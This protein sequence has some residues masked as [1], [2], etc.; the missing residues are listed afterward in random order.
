MIELTLIQKIC[1]AI[2]PVLFAI[3]V[4]EVAH[5]FVANLLGD[6]T[7]K[8][9]GR[10]SLNPFKHIDPIG[11]ILV[12]LLM[13]YFGGF[14]FGWAKPVPI[15]PRHFKRYRRD[16]ALVAAAGPFS[17]FLMASFWSVLMH[18]GPHSNLP[19]MLMCGIGVTINV[20]LAVLNLIPIPPLDGSR[21][22]SSLLPG[23]LSYYYSYIEPYGFFIILALYF[24]GVLSAIMDPIVQ[25]FIT[26][27]MQK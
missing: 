4:H 22:V 24:V 20:I 23:R 15:N 10:L 25:F 18:W 9:L 2:I 5:G 21:V 3:T 16:T 11:T 6:P 12:P 1:V 26:L 17:N 19:L 7:A 27:F 14:L 13:L 8:M